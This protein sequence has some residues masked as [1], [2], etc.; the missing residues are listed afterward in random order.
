VDLSG[1]FDG[2]PNV[3]DSS[4]SN[5]PEEQNFTVPSTEAQLEPYSTFSAPPQIFPFLDDAAA[6][7]DSLV[8]LTNQLDQ[9]QQGNPSV[10]PPSPVD[11][12]LAYGLQSGSPLDESQS[13]DLTD[14]NYQSPLHGSTASSSATSEELET[15]SESSTAAVQCD[16]EGC[17]RVCKD[18]GSLRHHRRHHVKLF[19]CQEGSCASTVNRFSTKR[20]LSRHQASA[21]RKE[22]RHCPHCQKKFNGSRLDNLK[23]HIKKFHSGS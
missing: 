22:S 23:R 3:F 7:T 21:H 6:L 20:D 5:Y 11:V 10:G 13:S 16:F 2:F 17:G 14:I 9:P 1:R 4:Y 19:S 12:F 18:H 15:P 8:L